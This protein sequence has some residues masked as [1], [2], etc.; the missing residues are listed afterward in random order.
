MRSPGIFFPSC[1]HQN[2]VQKA[3]CSGVLSFCGVSRQV[4][5]LLGGKL[6]IGS[7]CP[8]RRRWR[9]WNRDGIKRLCLAVSLCLCRLCWVQGRNQAWP[10]APGSGQTVACEL[11]QMPDLQCHPDRGVHQQVGVAPSTLPACIPLPPTS[12]SIVQGHTHN[13]TPHF[14]APA[15][16]CSFPSLALGSQGLSLEHPHIMPHDSKL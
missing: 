15:L 7:W 5:R 11:L 1:S 13:I 12:V 14:L 10:V 3:P 2:P 16:L 6:Y 9:P 8:E 4:S